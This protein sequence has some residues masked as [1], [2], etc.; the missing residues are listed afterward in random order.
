MFDP[1]HILVPVALDPD[2]DVTLAHQA[3]WTACDIA[4]KFGAKITLLHMTPALQPGGTSSLDLSGQVYKSFIEVMQAR[5]NLGRAKLHELE[6]DAKSRGLVVEGRIIESLDSTAQV[7]LEAVDAMGA[8]LMVI[9]SHGRQGLS[10]ML[11]RSVA[12]KI[13]NGSSV[14]VLLLHLPAQEGPQ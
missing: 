12:E 2:D 6:Q 14:P 7:I 5:I 9:C 8:D 10:R 13:A 4:L 3:L 11:F 1:K